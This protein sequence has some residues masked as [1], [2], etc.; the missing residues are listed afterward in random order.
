MRRAGSTS[1]TGST[2]LGSSLCLIPSTPSLKE[3]Q[4]RR[5]QL[6][7]L[8]SYL[9]RTSISAAAASVVVAI[10]DGLAD[11]DSG[12]DSETEGGER[13]TTWLRTAFGGPPQRPLSSAWPSYP[14]LLAG[15]I[16]IVCA[17]AAMAL[18]CTAFAADNGFHDH[19]DAQQDVPWL[20]S[21]LMASSNANATVGKVS[22]KG[23]MVVVWLS[24]LAGGALN[25]KHILRSALLCG[26]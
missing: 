10:G 3:K 26:V 1:P 23:V 8:H 19:G 4:Q 6:Q 13:Q 24:A 15:D 12:P 9:V 14:L 2:K 17:L 7:S 16:G 11:A 20:E 21:M 22:G 25:V 18:I 5:R